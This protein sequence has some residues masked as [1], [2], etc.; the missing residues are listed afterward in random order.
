MRN[1]SFFLTTW[2]IRQRVKTVTRR[3]GPRSAALKPGDRIQA[4]E[5]TQ[6]MKRGER[7]TPLAVLV[8]TEVRPEQLG[9]LLH[10]GPG[11]QREELR[12][13]GLLGEPDHRGQPIDTWADFITFFR[14]THPSCTPDTIVTRI[15]FRYEDPRA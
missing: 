13:E 4:V 1:L 6:G 14:Q 7:V 9:L 5:R 10:A 11:V 12:R 8:V 3:I 2:Q 15:A